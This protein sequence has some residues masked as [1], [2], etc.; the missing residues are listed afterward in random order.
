MRS[1]TCC[2]RWRSM[3]I[4]RRPRLS[5]ARPAGAVLVGQAG[6]DRDRRASPADR[7]PCPDSLA[8]KYAGKPNDHRRMMPA[9]VGS[10]GSAPPR[11]GAGHPRPYRPHGPDDAGAFASALS[12]TCLRR[13]PPRARI[14]PANGSGPRQTLSC[15]RGRQAA[16]LPGLELV[17]FPAAHEGFDLDAQGRHPFLGYGIRAGDLRI[18]HSGDCIPFA[19]LENLIAAF[20]PQIALLLVNGRDS[21]AACAPAS[22]AISRWMRLWRWRQ[23][24]PTSSFASLRYVRLQHGRPGAD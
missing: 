9:P 13:A 3:W 16:P 6:S 17:V 21:A 2:W 4:E 20:A 23:V 10:R 8:I 22:R 19:G 24:C 15:R 1:Q 12:P 5:R 14:R 18:Y 11:S 7:P